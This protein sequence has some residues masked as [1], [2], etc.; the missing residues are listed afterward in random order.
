MTD[1]DQNKD[2][3]EQIDSQIQELEVQRNLLLEKGIES[4]DPAAIIKAQTE[5]NKIAK[6]KDNN[7]K[8]YLYSPE[9]EFYN[10]LGYKATMKSLSYN[11][12]RQMSYSPFVW[13]V[14]VTRVNQVN[15]FS[16]FTTDLQKEGWTIRKK[17]GRFD[18][19]KKETTK[20]D[21]KIID[22]IATFLEN[23]GLGQ[24]WEQSDDFD[25]F[26]RKQ[27]I[28]TLTFDQATFEV[29]RTRGG[30]LYSYVSLDA[31]TI[32]LLDTLSDKDKKGIQLDSDKYDDINGYKPYYAQVWNEKIVT[33][34]IGKSD[35]QEQVAFY[36]W[37]LNFGVRNKMTD[38]RNNGYG[39]S[40]LEILVDIITYSLFGLHY[41]GNFFKQGS[42]PK[43]FFSI[44]GN[45][46]QDTLNEFKQ[47]WRQQVSGYQNAWKVPVMESSKDSKMQWND[48]GKTNEEMNFSGWIDFLQLLTCSIYTI[49][50][51]ELGFNFQKQ[52]QMFGQDGQ[53][54]RLDHSKNKG[55]KPLLQ[56]LMQRINKHIVTEINPNYEFVFTGIDLED[57]TKVL[58][59]DKMKSEAGFVSQE[60]MFEKY[61]GRKMNPEKDTILNQVYQ[62]AQQAKQFGGEESN[63][64]VD[65]MTGEP[66]EGTQ[67]PFDEYSKAE[68]DPFTKAMNDY[69][70][71]E[72]K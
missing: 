15:N 65:E 36:P 41:N 38:I 58:E 27:V 5:L 26:L 68:K 44:E 3:F 14:I 71:R 17:L 37:E 33:R 57:E 61:S 55:L 2:S 40:E 31:S 24:K 13:P 47:A 4:D 11:L 60:D 48:M 54:E 18:D 1:K 35:L 59:N 23:G 32:R 12:M 42:A 21:Q 20:G 52:A 6:K 19:A 63:Q 56:F 72:L 53:K 45:V 16:Q 66:D 25:D 30:D 62:Q 64:A 8:A 67:N 22:D 46:S 39:K 29:E 69:I 50:P 10:G 7:F 34:K 70:N 43:G 49:D 51:S 28:D 9:A